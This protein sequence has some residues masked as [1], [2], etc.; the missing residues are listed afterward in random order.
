[1]AKKMIINCGSCDARN[2]KEETLA[3]YESITINAGSVLVSRES[4]DLMNRYGVTMN[5]GDIKEIDQD[6]HINM[7]NGKLQIKSGDIVAGKCYLM[8]N[9]SL[10]IGPDTQK[11][12]EHYVGIHVNG[13]VTY[14]ESMSAFVGMLSVNGTTAS[15]PDG[16]VVLKRNAVVDRL[17]ALRAKKNLYWSARR[18]IMVD[19]QLDEAALMAKGA[20]FSAKEVILA[21]SKVESMIDLID[22][23]AEIIIVPD[24]TSVIMDDVTLNAATVKKYGKKL[25][26]IGDLKVFA[27]GAEALEQLV[28]LNVR[29]DASVTAELRDRLTEALTEISGEV[30]VSK[31]L[32]G[33]RIEDKMNLRISKWLLEQE[34]DG[35]TVS[36]CMKLTLDDDI[37]A[38]LILERLSVSDCMEVRCSADQE[39]AVAAVSEDVMWIGSAHPEGD[40]D[41]GSLVKGALSGTKALLDTKIVNAGDYVL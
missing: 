9:G 6:A 28:Y 3:A 2:V 13:S 33:R 26:I 39:A 30:K 11:V 34:T 38:E 19:P 32:K 24:G 16:A 14:P 1:M 35:I 41:I 29:G 15:Y 18:M 21:E 4:K 23:K 5:C 36:D 12:L 20:A 31:P 37:P 7:V 22:E 40:M 17:F 25:Y 8:V 10:D 27:E